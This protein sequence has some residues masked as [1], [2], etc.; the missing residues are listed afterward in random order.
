MPGIGSHR[1]QE[2]PPCRHRPPDR[3]HR[4]H[5]RHDWIVLRPEFR[6]LLAD[7]AN[8]VIDGVIFYDLDRLVR[9]SPP[10]TPPANTSPPPRT[11]QTAAHVPLTTLDVARPHRPGHRHH[12]ASHG[13]SP[14]RRVARPG[15]GAP[16]PPPPPARLRRYAGRRLLHLALYIREFIVQP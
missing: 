8:G 5:A 7:L 9:S 4:R 12:H 15:P 10:R 6:Q 14:P 2:P 11:D 1:D 16:S 3:R 13:T